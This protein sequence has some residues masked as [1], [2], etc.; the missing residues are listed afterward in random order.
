MP[1]PLRPPRFLRSRSASAKWD[2]G[3][4]VR[5]YL[6]RRHELDDVGTKY[7]AA[8]GYW[9]VDSASSCAGRI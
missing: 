3:L 5:A 2:G 7:V 4:S 6:V 1:R 8:Q 9:L